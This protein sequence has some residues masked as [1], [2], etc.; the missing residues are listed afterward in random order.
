MHYYELDISLIPNS[1]V[2]RDLLAAALG[3]V[4]FESFVDSERGLTA[5]VSEKLF[6]EE[7]LSSTLENLP[8]R[9]THVTYRINHI[10]SQDWNYEWERNFFRPITIEG[11]VVI[12]SSFHEDIPHCRYDIVIDPK[13]SFGT[14]HHQTTS[15]MLTYMLEQDLASHSFLDMGCGTA[16]LAILAKMKQ[17]DP[18]VAIDI[19]E[20]AYENALENIRLNHTPGIDVRLGDVNQV[21]ADERFDFVFA[22]INRNI[23]LEDIPVYASRMTAGGHLFVSGFYEEDLLAITQACTKQGLSLVSH[24]Q[25]D[26]WAAAHFAFKR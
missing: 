16:V 2:N 7:A 10:E 25:K 26:K 3:A 9:D 18:V 14:G 20:W 4:G 19:D 12:H 21:K 13:M 5:Y 24:K 6:D 15:L 23:L 22:N 1:E 17:A 11:Q 8:L